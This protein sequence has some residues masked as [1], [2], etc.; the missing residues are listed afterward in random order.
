VVTSHSDVHTTTAIESLAMGIPVVITKASDFPELDEYKAGIT[1]DSDSN[2]VCDAV[3]E[4]LNDEEKL[5]EYSKNA[6]KLIDEKFLLK[7]KI[8]EYEKMFEDVV[9]RFHKNLN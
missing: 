2:S 4:L 7:N 8:K 3:E 1:V 9:N 5:K 6:K